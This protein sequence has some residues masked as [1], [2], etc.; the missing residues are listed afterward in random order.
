MLSSRLASLPALQTLML[1]HADTPL[2]QRITQDK[3]AMVQVQARTP[4]SRI[5]QP[6]E[7]SGTHRS[8]LFDLPFC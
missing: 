2:V 3:E 6:S 8:K 7:V 5:A 1:S 4:M